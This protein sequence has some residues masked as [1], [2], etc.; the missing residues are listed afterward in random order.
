VNVAP[1]RAPLAKGIPNLHERIRALLTWFGS[2]AGPWSGF[3]GYEEVA[4]DL[5]LD[6]STSD[7]LAAMDEAPLTE[8]QTEGAA[9][10]FGGWTFSQKRPEDRKKLPANWKQTLLAHSLKSTNDDKRGRAER[11]FK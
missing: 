5:L 10:L 9:R 2:G 7:I 1:L 8:A 3:P 4:E 11:A 6:Y